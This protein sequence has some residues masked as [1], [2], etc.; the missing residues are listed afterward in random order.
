MWTMP[1]ACEAV[2]FVMKTYKWSAA[3]LTVVGCKLCVDSCALV[4]DLR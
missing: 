2:Q 1:E 3:L 4:G